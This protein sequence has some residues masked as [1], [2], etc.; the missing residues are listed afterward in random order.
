MRMILLLTSCMAVLGNVCQSHAAELLRYL[1]A[2]TNRD[3]RAHR[4][5]NRAATHALS[6]PV[7]RDRA[8]RLPARFL[9][10][11]GYYRTSILTSAALHSAAVH[12]P[13]DERGESAE[14]EAAFGKVRLRSY[15]HFLASRWRART[16][17][18]A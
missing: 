18:Y 16:A 2:N 11:T 13:G 5:R 9:G 15:V 3:S 17:A 6:M 8:L 14:E 1:A 12:R 4:L 10:C 7:E